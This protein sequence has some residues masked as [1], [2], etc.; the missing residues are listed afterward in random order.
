MLEL[1][2]AREMEALTKKISQASK[3]VS[4]MPEEADP[5]YAT[6]SDVDEIKAMMAQVLAATQKRKPGRPKK[7]EE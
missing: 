1:R 6:K 5:R 3:S 4:A 2:K 7:D